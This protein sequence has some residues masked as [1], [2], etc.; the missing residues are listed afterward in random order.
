MP[1]IEEEMRAH[2]QRALVVQKLCESSA[3]VANADLERRQ[4]GF[5][6]GLGEIVE[7]FVS[8]LERLPKVLPAHVQNNEMPPAGDPFYD[9]PPRGTV[10]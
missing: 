2:R 7:E 3:T 4:E 9:Y 1:S 5:W 10:Q 8:F 6:F